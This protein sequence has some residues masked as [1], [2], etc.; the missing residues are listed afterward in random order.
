MNSMADHLNT[1]KEA[2]VAGKHNDIKDLVKR[3][4][5][6]GIAPDRIIRLM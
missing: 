5:D 4:I 3:A 1:I 2:V 6:D